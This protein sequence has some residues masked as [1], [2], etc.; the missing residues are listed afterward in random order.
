[1]PTFMKSVRKPRKIQKLGKVMEFEI[2]L[3]PHFFFDFV[4]GRQLDMY[5]FLFLS[6][7]SSEILQIWL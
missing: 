2:S 4:T 1:M 5:N 7:K 3:K 6:E